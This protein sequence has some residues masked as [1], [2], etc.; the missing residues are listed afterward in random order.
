M[1]YS[2]ALGV[3]FVA[4]L[5]IGCGKTETDACQ[6]LGNKEIQTILEKVQ[7]MP[8]EAIAEN[9]VAVLETNYGDIAIEFFQDV[10]PPHAEAF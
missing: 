3:L 5:F 10:A 6:P 7:S 4:I 1:K 9:E 8:L 2:I